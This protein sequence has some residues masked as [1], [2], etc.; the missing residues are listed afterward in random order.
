MKAELVKRQDRW[1]LYGQDGHKIASTAHNPFGKLSIENCESIANGDNLVDKK[2]GIAQLNQMFTCGKLYQSSQN[3]AY[4][5]E[6][7]LKHFE[8]NTWDVK[9][10][11]ESKIEIS[12][13]FTESHTEFKR[14]LDKN[15]CIILNRIA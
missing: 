8:P 2:Y 9:I 11:M 6:N 7:V 14:K 1:D 4:S 3:E 5:F 12:K 10:E 15:G 13:N